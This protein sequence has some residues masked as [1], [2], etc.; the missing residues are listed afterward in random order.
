MGLCFLAS[1][2]RGAERPIPDGLVFWVDASHGESLAV[3]DAGKAYQWSDRSGRSNHLY[4]SD[5]ERPTVIPNSMHGRSVVRFS[6][7]QKMAMKRFVREAAGDGMILIVW[8]RT[9]AQ[10]GTVGWQRALSS[11]A[12]ESP[13]NKQPHFCAPACCISYSVGQTR[14]PCD[15][16]PMKDTPTTPRPS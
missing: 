6:G 16:S 15:S 7:G 3:D 13:D 12:T 4:A 9:T 10:A 14:P 2:V 8:Q 11:Y 1:P 5:G